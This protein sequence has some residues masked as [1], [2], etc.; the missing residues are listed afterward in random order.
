M[1]TAKTL[2]AFPP[3]VRNH[4]LLEVVLQHAVWLILLAL[5]AAFCLLIPAY[6]QTGIFLNILEQSTFVG[7]LAVG[8]SIAII[9]G[10]MDLSIESTMALS[11]ML[12]AAIG[13]A[14]GTEGFFGLPWLVVPA[15]LV[16]A[17]V[18]GACIGLFNSMIVLKFGINAFIATLATYI[19][20]RGSVVAFSGGRGIFGMP[21]EL[22]LIATAHLL[23]IP[24]LAWITIGIFLVFTFILSKTPFGRYVYL[25]GG[26]A[27]APFRAGINTG[28][29]AVWSFVICG[30]LAAFAGWLLAAR[31]AGATANL[32]IGMLFEAFAAV[33]IGGVSL[34][35]GVG[36]LSGVFA[37]VLLLSSIR[38]AIN[39][40]GMPPQ[41]TQMIQGA[42]VLAAVLLDSVKVSIRARYL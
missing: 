2:E 10:Q 15:T 12:T 38:T 34:K 18:L 19:F 4:R 41:Y 31:S 14:S 8:L 39:L 35:G 20:L 27:V 1:D 28:R 17:L 42:L 6:A 5:L 13:A 25:Y 33:V 21:A 30:M 32:G 29:I 3:R 11:A 24:A 7:I 36:R 40:L 26:N 37:G 9:A 22:R 23:G 16:M